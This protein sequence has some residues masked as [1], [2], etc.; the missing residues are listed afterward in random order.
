MSDDV[1]EYFRRP[2]TVANWWN[3]ED[4]RDPH[5]A[6][7]REQL[8]WVIGQFEWQ[9]AQVLDVGTGKGRFAVPFAVSQ[10]RVVAVDIAAQM[11][12]EA[13]ARARR[14][15]VTVQLVQSDAERLPFRSASFD[16]VSCMEMLMHVPRPQRA[17]T[18]VAR[19][20]HPAGR[21]VLSITNKWRLN[22][23]ADLPVTLARTLRLNRM[24]A[25]PRIAWY[26]SART[27]R[28]FVR[29]AGLHV[30]CLR[31]QGLLQSGARLRLTRHRSLP[32]V[33]PG[34]ARWFFSRVEPGLRQGPLL[35]VMGTIQATVSSEGG[36]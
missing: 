30:D 2:G 27:F 28:R 8:T 19:V 1:K 3:P 23:L 13:R 17:I 24:P 33:H 26:Y 35:R 15:G 4:E 18:E 12:A 6:H 29:A 32:L 11:L 36:P 14:A 16:V 10:G 20:M 34:F 9:G 31:G 22:A 5:F 7:F 25:G 21:G